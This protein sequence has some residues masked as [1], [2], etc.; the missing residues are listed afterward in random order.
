MVHFWRVLKGFINN[1][2]RMWYDHKHCCCRF[3]PRDAL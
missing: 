1:V 2:Q 3:L